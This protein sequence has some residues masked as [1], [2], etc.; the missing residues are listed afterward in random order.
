MKKLTLGQIVDGIRKRDNR[1]ITSVYKEIYPKINYHI[2]NNGGTADDA[3]D[4]FQE[5]IIVVFRQIQNGT[6]EIKTDFEGYVYGIARLIWLKTLR[7]R[8]IHERN[9]NKMEGDVQ[10]SHPADEIIDEEMEMNLFRKYF[11]K[12]GK[13][14]QKV[15]KMATDG[16]PYETIAKEMGYKSEKIVRNRKYKC[17]ESLIEMIKS[18]PDYQKLMEQRK[19]F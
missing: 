10:V 3:K 7:N 6:F 12:L 8:S 9:I 19:R 11:L 16:I 5:A 18:D 4:V 14:C 13:E 17:K 15:L 1:I 2:L